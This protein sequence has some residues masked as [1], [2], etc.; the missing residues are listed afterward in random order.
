[1]RAKFK[2]RADAKT[3]PIVPVEKGVFEA[4]R[5]TQPDAV[6]R[7]VETAGFTAATGSI[8]LVA[9]EDGALSMA[10]LGVGAHDDFWA[11][12]DLPT[13]LPAGTYRIDAR[14]EADAATGAALGWAL[15]AYAFDR[16][17]ASPSQ[18]VPTLVW[19]AGADR[20]HVERAAR[21]TTTY[22]SKISR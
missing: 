5:K 13:R 10:L 17:R 8:S 9:A 2:A 16:Y 12:A 22:S 14:M 20:A 21:A 6:R 4:W 7:W 1:M 19:P 3:V 15:G 18:P 11:Y